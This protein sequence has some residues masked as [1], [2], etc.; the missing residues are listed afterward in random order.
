MNWVKRIMFWK[1]EKIA[2]ELET[3]AL[4]K[5]QLREAF[6]RQDDLLLAVQKMKRAREKYRTTFHS[7][8]IG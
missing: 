6:L 1:R 5:A 3:E 7:R 4:F 8:P 2:E